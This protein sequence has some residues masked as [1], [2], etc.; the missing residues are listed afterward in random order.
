M[1]YY[2]YC[3]NYKTTTTYKIRLGYIAARGDFYGI[4]MLSHCIDLSKRNKIIDSFLYNTQIIS[5]KC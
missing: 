1:S 2:E 3:E 5:T 4:K